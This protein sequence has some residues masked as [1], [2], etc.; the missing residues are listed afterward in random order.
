MY[1]I[2]EVERIVEQLRNIYPDLIVGELQ[3]KYYTIQT[4]HLYHRQE[5]KCPDNLILIFEYVHSHFKCFFRIDNK[6]EICIYSGHL[7]NLYIDDYFKLLYNF[8]KLYEEEERGYLL[9][10][11]KKYARHARDYES[12]RDSSENILAM[13]DPKKEK[14][15][16]QG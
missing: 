8:V 5:I 10:L 16:G 12:I 1:L 13:L 4:T 9:N 2:K 14:E 6:K 15:N 3:D 7:S 11:R